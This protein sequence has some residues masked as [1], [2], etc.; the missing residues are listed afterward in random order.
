MPEPELMKRLYPEACF[1]CGHWT[2]KIRPCLYL[3]KLV[4]KGDP[5]FS[6]NNPGRCS[7][8]DEVR[9]GWNW[10]KKWTKKKGEP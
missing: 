3:W 7:V 8:W 9:M 4:R 5:F 10:C 2:M 6:P 1:N